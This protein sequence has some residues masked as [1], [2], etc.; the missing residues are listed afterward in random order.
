[1]KHTRTCIYAQT[2]QSN[3][4][5]RLNLIIIIFSVRLCVSL[6]L[7]DACISL[8]IISVDAKCIFCFIG[9]NI[10]TYICIFC[11]E[12]EDAMV[13]L[14]MMMMLIMGKI[15]TFIEFRSMTY[16]QNERFNSTTIQF[17]IIKT[18]RKKTKK[19]LDST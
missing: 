2:H 3:L 5:M 14:L 9:L 15:H 6:M 10:C 4:K 16:P 8:H 17:K 19:L 12:K 11:K 18:E 7:L 13:V 1:M